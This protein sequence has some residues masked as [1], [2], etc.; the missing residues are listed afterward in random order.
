MSILRLA[1][2]R[3]STKKYRQAILKT[4]KRVAIEADRRLLVAK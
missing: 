4:K 1:R 2:V 3:Y